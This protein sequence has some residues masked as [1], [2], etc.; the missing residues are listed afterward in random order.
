MCFSLSERER[1]RGREMG[2][3]R[4][5]GREKEK[6]REVFKQFSVFILKISLRSSFPAEHWYS[7][8]FYIAIQSFTP[9]FLLIILRISIP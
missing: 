4:E 8:L 2:V 3:E 9:A 5:R 1:E 7:L 6:E